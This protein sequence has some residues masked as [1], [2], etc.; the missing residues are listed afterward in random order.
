MDQVKAIERLIAPTVQ[1]MGY[2]LVRAR[3][4]GDRRR[5]LQVMAERTDGQAM[6]VDDCASISRAVSA[7]L[8][9]EDPI[10]G[11]YDLE[12]SSPGIDRPLVRLDDFARFAGF[13]A[14]VE[15]DAASAGRRRFKGR[16][17]GVAGQE[18]RI[19]LGGAAGVVTV[20]FDA[21]SRAKLVLTD[22]LIRTSLKETDSG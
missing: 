1:A 21:I 17:E 2:A 4:S 11:R 19:D 15:T 7:L 16:L 20:P 13:Q 22:E 5:T 10:R 8:D 12:V 9:V 3:L 6:T 18:V 14:T